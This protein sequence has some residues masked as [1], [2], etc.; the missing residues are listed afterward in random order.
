M[1]EFTLR[2]L[3][4]FAALPDHPTLSAAAV[5][6]HISEPALSQAITG[7]EK[8]VGEQLCVRRKAKGLQLTPAG[9]FFAERARRLLRE[10]GELASELAE[11]NGRL[12][13]PVRLGCYTGLAS[14]VLPPVLAGFPALHPEVVLEIEVGSQDELLSAL[15]AGRLD[16]AIV[17]DLQL[18][19]GLQR[20]NIYETEVV[21]ILAADHRL[22][23][24]AA[25]DLTELAPEPLIMLESTPSTLNTR[26]MFAERGLNPNLL[27]SVPVIEL[28]RA[29]V[30]RGL[31]YSLLMSRPNSQDTTTEGR[32]VVVR[33]LAPRSGITSVTAVWPEQVAPSRRTAAVL[34]FATSCFAAPEGTNVN[35]QYS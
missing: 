33:P 29:L 25:V 22:A 7:L 4:L 34:D 19:P 23:G 24:E 5:A 26:L 17:Y 30:G 3:E 1:V 27:M 13:G 14:N 31:G 12:K 21:A 9:Q 28:V 20:R 32:R 35:G 10:A 11:V 18:P 2:Q 8:S 15:D 6:L 16:A